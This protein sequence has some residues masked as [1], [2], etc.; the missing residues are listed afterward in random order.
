MHLRVFVFMCA[1]ALLSIL[2]EPTSLHT[3]MQGGKAHDV[4]PATER[5]TPPGVRLINNN[6]ALG[7][8]GPYCCTKKNSQ[9]KHTTHNVRVGCEVVR[10]PVQKDHPASCSAHPCAKLLQ[11]HRC[12]HPHSDP[13]R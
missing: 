2:E 11:R 8:G 1:L 10:V 5:L 3:K 9:S 6:K 13:P 4:A 12:C 7:Y